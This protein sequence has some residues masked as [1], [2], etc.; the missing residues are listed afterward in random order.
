MISPH[1]CVC[2]CVCV[3]L[4]LETFKW[5]WEII[6]IIIIIISLYVVYSEYCNKFM[7]SIISHLICSVKL[8]VIGMIAPPA[9]N[10]TTT[11]TRTSPVNDDRKLIYSFH[12]CIPFT[13]W[14]LPLRSY[15]CSF[16][17][18]CRYSSPRIP[19]TALDRFVF[20]VFQQ[21]LL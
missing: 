6:I 5:G 21:C 2:V 20:P 14:S 11:I 1:V 3:S 4:C 19:A 7:G 9:S 17:S 16:L 18:S 8:V 15:S 13:C 12:F 10:T